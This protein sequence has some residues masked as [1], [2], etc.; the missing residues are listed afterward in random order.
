LVGTVVDT[1]GGVVDQLLSILPLDQQGTSATSPQSASKPTPT[2]TPTPAPTHS[3]LL[4][5]LLGGL[6]GH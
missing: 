1:L 3:D 5:G 4:G 2:P 6:S